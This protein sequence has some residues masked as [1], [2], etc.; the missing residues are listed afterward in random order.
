[1]P[2]APRSGSEAL[3]RTPLP[4]GVGGSQPPL[5]SI[6][7]T[8]AMRDV[9]S[10]PPSPL[11]SGPISAVQRPSGG[12]A[13]KAS[14]AVVVLLVLLVLAALGTAAWILAARTHHVQRT[15]SPI[16]WWA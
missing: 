5:P 13:G 2:H 10:V 8:Q 15:V 6:I 12:G 9:S 14:A 7:V 11:I 4:P 16:T 1:M 3:A